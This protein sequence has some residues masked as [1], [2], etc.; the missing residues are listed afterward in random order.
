MRRTPS[1]IVADRVQQI[2]RRRGLTAQELAERC[3]ELGMSKLSAAAI[4]NIE[5]GR[6]VDGRRRRD[7]TVD[8]WLVLAVALSVH[9]VDLLIP[10]D[11]GMSA[12]PFAPSRAESARDVRDWVRGFKLLP[13]G[14]WQKHLSEAPPDDYYLDDGVPSPAWV[15]RE[16]EQWEEEP[17]R[18]RR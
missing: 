3:A 17:D 15:R 14:D 1:D 13:G 11:A 12:Y 7:V 5:T 9:P 18:G 4:S 6:R 10:P 8:E 2:R 16:P